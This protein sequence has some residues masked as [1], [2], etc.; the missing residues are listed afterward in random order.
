MIE[1]GK[2]NLIVTAHPDDETLWCGGLPIR[3]KDRNWTVVCCTTPR[4]DPIRAVKFHDACRILGFKKVYISSRIEPAYDG[5]IEFE[6]YMYQIGVSSFDAIFTHNP[7]GE[8][9]HPHHKQV[10]RFVQANCSDTGLFFFGYGAH[11]GVIHD[12]ITLDSQEYSQKLA[13]LKCYDHQSPLDA[14]PKWKALLDR[15]FPN[16]G[17]HCESYC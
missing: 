12:Q 7:G 10:N 16:G 1:P 13:A 15:Y 11:V 8:Y 3:F 9:G 2:N 17:F 4:A 6:D 5:V 14:Q